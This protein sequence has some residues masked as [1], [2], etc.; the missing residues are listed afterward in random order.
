MNPCNSATQSCPGF[1]PLGFFNLVLGFFK[2][3]LSLI[4]IQLQVRSSCKHSW[5]TDKLFADLVLLPKKSVVK[6]FEDTF[7]EKD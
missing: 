3:H 6:Y 7:Y 2:I 1:S 5:K 4:T